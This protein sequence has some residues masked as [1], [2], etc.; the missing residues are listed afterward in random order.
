[1]HCISVSETELK[2]NSP[3]C[4]LIFRTDTHFNNRADWW[5][6]RGG[7]TKC[8]PDKMPTGHNANQ[9]LAFCPDFFLWLAFCPSQ[10]FGWHFVRTT[11]T[12]FGFFFQIMKIVFQITF[13]K[14]TKSRKTERRKDCTHPQCLNLTLVLGPPI[15]SP[16]TAE[17]F[18]KQ[19]I[20]KKHRLFL[21]NS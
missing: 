17:L 7:R 2:L 1:M 10:L 13:H 11:S 8:Q 18:P 14:I 12:C 15:T 4:K 5:C 3:S 6:I 21:H 20:P 16:K 9:R 19:F